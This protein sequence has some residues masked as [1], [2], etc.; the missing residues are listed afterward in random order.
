MRQGV[1]TQGQHSGKALAA[2]LAIACA[3]YSG[4]SVAATIVAP[5][6]AS[7][8]SVFS[9]GNAY[10]IKNTIN[11]SGLSKKYV[12]G[13]TDFGSYLASKPQ[14]TSSA[15][16]TE[17]FS[18]DYDRRNLAIQT[19]TYGFSALTSINGFALWN[20][21]FAGIGTA[22]LLSSVDGITFTPLITIKPV[23]SKFAACRQGRSL[24][25]ASFLVRSHRHVVLST[26][27]YRLCGRTRF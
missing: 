10:A 20:E 18:Q 19:V 16:G 6:T 5:V 9:S 13:V 25:G 22:Q 7:A 26:L 12:S 2:A 23:A 8:T 27:D 14:H 21:E 17:W 24:P 3:T 1:V 4:H 15:I 11:Q